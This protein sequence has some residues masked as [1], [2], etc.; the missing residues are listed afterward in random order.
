MKD[1]VVL[2]C[3]VYPNYF[4]IA[5]KN[6]DNNNIS[7]IE[8]KGKNE[9]L[10]D[11]QCHK[12]KSILYKRTTFGF[13]SN[14]YDI[15]IILFAL[16]KRTCEE[17]HKLSDR[18]I[19]GN[20]P[21]WK[22][23]KDFHLIKPKKMSHFDISDPSP[24]VRVSLKLYGGR[25]NSKRLQDLPIE[26]GTTLTNKEMEETL[27][28]C[29]NDLN[30]TIDLYRKVED[31]IRLRYE[32]SEQ[33][34]SD[35]RSK[36]DAQIA[37]TVIKSV[38]AK[39]MPN[40]RVTRPRI[41]S[42]CTFKYDI[43]SYIK[44]NNEKLNKALEFISNH[45]FELDG[46]G[47]I[48]LPK[49]LKSMKIDIGK[50]SYQLGIGGIHSTEKKQTIIPTGNQILCERDVASYYPAIILNLKLYPRHLGPTFLEVYKDI[51]AKRLRAKRS[52]DKLMNE[53][54]K[55]VING[56]FGKLGSKYSVLYSPDLM[57]AVT[58]T[59]Q[60]ALLMLI[61]RLENKNI[62]II[63]A[64][65]DGFVAIMDKSQYETFDDIC[66]CWELDTS[67]ELEE[68]KYKALYSRDV[69]N[70]LAITEKGNKGKGVFAIN[71]I[72]KNPTATICVNAV[73]DFLTKNKAIDKTIASCKD[74]TQFLT[75]RSVTGGA[76]WQGQY[77]GRVV[78]W[79]YSTAG[80]QISYK[81]NGNKVPKSD[82][83]RPVMELEEFPQDIDYER[84]IKESEQIIEDIGY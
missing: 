79:I 82:N 25:L 50:S 44:F 75:V 61:E 45:H 55:V 73:I 83:S 4:L 52:G 19:E 10:N 76:E 34:G 22:T 81:K 57:M 21:G 68:T 46:K 54:L 3:E 53:S 33:Y 70:Y 63:S 30:T 58:L 43:P 37:E 59:G 35:L 38:L 15:P 29:I 51:V 17:I 65:T 39:K 64:N 41:D 7:T 60:L 16:N 13:N 31:R 48:K 8:V 27:T 12:L 69:N 14:K 1:L 6:I 28:Y 80:D 20:D 49:E 32:M 67:F 18:I 71:Q 5:F 2:D 78:R 66:F 77:L 36:S 47:S 74:I 56:S 26:P 11:E 24:G 62:S 40:K 84:Y 9:S 42:S 72:S 23:M